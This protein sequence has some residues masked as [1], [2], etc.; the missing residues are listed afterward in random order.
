M[1]ARRAGK[2]GIT[3][4]DTAAAAPVDRTMARLGGGAAIVSAI[5]ALVYAVGFVVLKDARAYAP[6]LLAGGLLSAV[7]LVAVYEWIRGASPGV[8]LLGLLFGFAGALGATAHGG[9]DLANVINP[10]EAAVP[11][12]PFAVDPRGL[13]TFGLSGLGVLALSWTARRAG[14]PAGL[15]WFGLALGALLIVV[16]LGRLI[17]LDPNS[18]LILVP[19]AVAALLVSPIWY[20]WVGRELLAIAR[21]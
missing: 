15:V 4:A 11:D 20:T 18:P 8:A 9:F 2:T 17:V 19:A 16:Y 3:A 12:L 7:A 13:L 21:T 6:A 5:L 14:A 1:D 10:P